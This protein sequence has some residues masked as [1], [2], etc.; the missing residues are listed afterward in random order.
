MKGRHPFESYRCGEDGL[1]GWVERR[2]KALPFLW[3]KRW[4]V[5]QPRSSSQPA[6]LLFY[7]KSIDAR[8]EL[9][10]NL[11]R[12]AVLPVIGQK[13]IFKLAHPK[14][15]TVYVALPTKKAPVWK[16][17]ALT[18]SEFIHSYLLPSSRHDH[19]RSADGD[20]GLPFDRIGYL[21]Q[22]ALIEQLPALQEDFAPPQYCALGELSNINTWLGTSGTVTSLHFDSYDNLLTQVAGYKYVRLYDPSQTPF[23]YR[24]AAASD[25]TDDTTTK[26]DEKKGKEKNDGDDDDGHGN[27]EEKGEMMAISAQSAKAQGNFSAVVNIESPDWSRYPL[28]R[29]AV[30]TETILG[31]GEMLFIPQNCWHYVR[32][33]TTSFSLNFWF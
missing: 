27:E 12:M 2:N 8:P 19:H 18:L 16:E 28:L 26:P 9:E 21:A 4:A 13:P 24:D 33:L 5:L 7:K 22:H 23:L 3:H 1:E 29:E 10:I 32:S 20:E 17:R 30:Y 15:E 25:S 11:E 31:P 6:H 14:Y